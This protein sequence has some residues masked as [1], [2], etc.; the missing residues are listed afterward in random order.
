MKF[1]T[2][3][4]Q[5]GIKNVDKNKAIS[6]VAGRKHTVDISKVPYHEQK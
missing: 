3:T 4:L 2:K 5:N 6:F 1:P